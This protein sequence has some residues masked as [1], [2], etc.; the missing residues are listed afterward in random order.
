MGRQ[1]G[2]LLL[3]MLFGSVQHMMAGFLDLW[4]ILDK[5]MPA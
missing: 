3:V 4:I 5:I 1:A 2:I